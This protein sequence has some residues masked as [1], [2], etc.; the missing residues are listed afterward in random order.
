[1]VFGEVISKCVISKC[2]ASRVI[3]ARDN[4]SSTACVYKLNM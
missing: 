1:M 2:L 3:K 4:F